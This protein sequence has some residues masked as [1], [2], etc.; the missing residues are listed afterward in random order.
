VNEELL[1]CLKADAWFP[2]SSVEI[3]SNIQREA[4]S[5]A[6]EGHSIVAAT[7]IFPEC[8]SGFHEWKVLALLKGR[9]W[10]LQHVICMDKTIKDKWRGVWEELAKLHKV[11]LTVLL[12]YTQ[13][14]TTH[15]PSRFLVIHV[16]AALKF[17]EGPPSTVSERP[18]AAEFWENCSRNAVNP[19]QNFIGN[20][21]LNPAH[22]M[23][24]QQLATAFAGKDR[25]KSK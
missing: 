21:V 22:S 18:A 2:E 23:S 6:M 15:K 9:G 4:E 7:C 10:P 5:W 1:L 14:K 16:N 17:T 13:L 11:H 24:W 20:G 8:G 12:S 19:P 25:G 3:L